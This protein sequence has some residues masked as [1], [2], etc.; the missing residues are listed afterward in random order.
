[1]IKLKYHFT[2]VTA[3]NGAVALQKVR[4]RLQRGQSPF[5][6]ILMDCNMPVM[7]GFESAMRITEL[8]HIEGT[9]MPY[10]VALTAQE[11]VELKF[12]CQA[13][14]MKEFF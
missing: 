6:L 10:I 3:A 5:K 13:H 1:M 11:S 2:P 9:S 12:K 8:C 4:E 14:G 7:D